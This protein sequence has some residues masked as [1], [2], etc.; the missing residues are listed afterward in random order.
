MKILD[1][2]GVTTLINIIKNNFAKSNSPTLTGTPTAPT[3]T[4][5][6][7]NTQIAT[8][9]FVQNAVSNTVGGISTGVQSVGTG[10]SDGTISVDGSD[11]AVKGLK[12]AAYTESNDYA[13]TS[14]N[15]TSNT[16]NA[17]TGYVKASSVTAIGTSDT[18]NQ[19]IGK[20]EKALDGLNGKVETSLVGNQASKIPQYSSEGHLVLPSGI[21]IW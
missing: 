2:I 21:E 14:H 4:A 20:L 11:V 15:Q 13:P 7:N 6:T 5:G 17:M 19:A 3:A 18:L 8:T 9:A 10:S 12:S 1:T 16:I